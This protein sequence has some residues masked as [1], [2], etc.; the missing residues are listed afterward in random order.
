MLAKKPLQ[1]RA[2]PKICCR[3]L[4]RYSYFLLVE[5]NF[6]IYFYLK[7][8]EKIFFKFFLKKGSNHKNIYLFGG[9]KIVTHVLCLSKLQYY[10]QHKLYRRHNRHH[11]IEKG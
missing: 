8:I 5:I 11:I 1:R 7:L 9:I 2:E 4:L 10:E 6:H 3:Q